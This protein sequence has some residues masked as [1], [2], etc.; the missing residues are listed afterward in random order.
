MWLI[1]IACLLAI[2]CAA[3][4][5]GLVPP[6]HANT[7]LRIGLNGIRTTRGSLRPHAR[8]H[9]TEI[10]LEAQV[11]RGF[12]AITPANRVVFSRNIPVAVHQRLRNVLLNQ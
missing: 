3:V 7:I 6:P 1:P 2:A 10:L 8:E 5:F 12:I 11:S 4:G 9:L